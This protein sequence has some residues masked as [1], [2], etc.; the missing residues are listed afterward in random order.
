[1]SIRYV[2]CDMYKCE[3]ISGLQKRLLLTL[4]SKL[5]FPF[6]SALVLYRFTDYQLVYRQYSFLTVDFVTKLFLGLIYSQLVKYTLLDRG[7]GQCQYL[8]SC[9]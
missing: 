5:V 9:E 8:T 6:L 4:L 1:M 7:L 2:D 3:G